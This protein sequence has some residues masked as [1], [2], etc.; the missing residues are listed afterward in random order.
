MADRIEERRGLAQIASSSVQRIQFALADSSDRRII[1]AK[2]L[3]RVKEISVKK[4]FGV[5]D[6]SIPLNMEERITII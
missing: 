5:F 4:L 1:K 3:M 6:H 2:G